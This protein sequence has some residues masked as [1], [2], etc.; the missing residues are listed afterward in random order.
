MVDQMRSPEPTATPGR[1]TDWYTHALFRAHPCW[2]SPDWALQY[3]K[4]DRA[5][6]REW[7]R[8]CRAAHIDSLLFVT[9]QHDGQCVYATSLDAPTIGTDFLADMCAAAADGG[10]R[11]L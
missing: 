9:K 5:D 2:I 11:L 1:A 6:A 10:I 3:V 8:L 7:M 4:R